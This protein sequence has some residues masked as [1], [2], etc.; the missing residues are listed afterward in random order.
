M[1]PV[2]TGLLPLIKHRSVAV[3]IIKKKEN[4]ASGI[5]P[6]RF[7]VPAR[8]AAMKTAPTL[9]YDAPECISSMAFIYLNSTLAIKCHVRSCSI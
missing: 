5:I 2:K 7:F 1:V 8:G 3:A 4:A 9:H 6:P